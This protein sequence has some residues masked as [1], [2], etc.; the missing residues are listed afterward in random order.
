M[1][2]LVQKPKKK[3]AKKPE[4]L[5]LIA[6][7]S[8]EQRKLE[9]KIKKEFARIRANLEDVRQALTYV[10]AATSEDDVAA[11]LKILEKH[12]KYVR[13]GGA[14]SRGATSHSRLLRKLG[15]VKATHG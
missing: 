7:E 15:K 3:A 14:F 4:T 5:D 2:T 6:E 11:R 13:R 8:K 1:G 12:V 9:K 10:E